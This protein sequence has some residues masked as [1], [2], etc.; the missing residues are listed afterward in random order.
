MD[1][2]QGQPQR[3]NWRG[4]CVITTEGVCL[5]AGK[6]GQIAGSD[7]V[8]DGWNAGSTAQPAYGFPGTP[9]SAIVHAV[10]SSSGECRLE[11]VGSAGHPSDY[12]SAPS[13]SGHGPWCIYDAWTFLTLANEGE[14][15]PLGKGSAGEEVRT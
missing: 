7:V 5:D 15:R 1:C 4:G 10:Q 2:D 11:L 8:R 9:P 14:R 12:D 3:S 6:N 13:A